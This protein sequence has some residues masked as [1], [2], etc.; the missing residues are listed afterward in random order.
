MKKHG[1]CSV[2]STHRQVS[3][4][5]MPP[6]DGFIRSPI[7]HSQQN[8]WYVQ[9][10]GVIDGPVCGANLSEA[11]ESICVA[12]CT[13]DGQ[14]SRDSKHMTQP[15]EVSTAFVTFKHCYSMLR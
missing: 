13:A 7:S 14:C 6:Q 12:A 11:N 1:R 4:T 10:I 2:R 5:C 3:N 9:L 15:L 8:I